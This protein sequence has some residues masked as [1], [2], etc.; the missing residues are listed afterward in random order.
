MISDRNLVILQW[1][2]GMGTKSG[3]FAQLGDIY[4]ATIPT[5]AD[6]IIK[7]GQL[8]GA[9]AE[10]LNHIVVKNYKPINITTAEWNNIK[11][12]LGH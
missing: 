8:L 1:Q 6:D 9:Y 10:E 7:N 5:K 2:I 3:D 4:L 12:W 11:S